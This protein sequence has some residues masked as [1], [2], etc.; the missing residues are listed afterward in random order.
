M[1]AAVFLDKDGTLIP[2][3]PYNIDPELITL[4]ED[5]V[6]GLKL[7]YE[8]G[9]Q[10]IVLSNQSGIAHGYFTEEALLPVKEKL[11]DLL[12]GHDIQLSGFYYCPHHSEGLI[13][14]YTV[15]CFCRKPFPGMFFHAAAIHNIDLAAS[16][17]I[18]DIL[19]DVEAGNRAGCRTILIDNGNETE[20]LR[21]EYRIPTLTCKSI[22]EA[23]QYILKEEYAIKLA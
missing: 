9:Y 4:H 13:D 21:G 20:W 5:S 17:M 2:D 15:D 10:L 14:E 18:G 6:N 11:D 7:L 1:N 19:H 22:N 12:A 16:W 3:I 8:R 23:A